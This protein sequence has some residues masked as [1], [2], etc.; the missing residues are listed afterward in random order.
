MGNRQL[1][2]EIVQVHMVN[3]THK[4][5]KFLEFEKTNYFINNEFDIYINV[6]RGW[7]IVRTENH[8]I[9]YSISRYIYI[10]KGTKFSIYCG[11]C[12]V[13][14]IEVDELSW[15][16]NQIVEEEFLN[17][18]YIGAGYIRQGYERSKIDKVFKDYYSNLGYEI[19]TADTDHESFNR[20]AFRNVLA[21][22]FP[23]EIMIILDNDGFYT[24]DQLNNAVKHAAEDDI[25]VKPTNRILQVNYFD[26]FDPNELRKEFDKINLKEID[27][28]TNIKRSYNDY[29]YEY[30]GLYTGIGWVLKTKLW[31][32][33]D[34]RCIGW[35]HE[36]LIFQHSVA[37]TIGNMPSLDN[38]YVITIN[39]PRDVTKDHNT[40]IGNEY[41]GKTDK[42]LLLFMLRQYAQ[43]GCGGQFATLP[44]FLV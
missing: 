25:V 39:H 24:K 17:K 19:I 35:G 5:L 22:V 23:N 20:S 11:K 2:T 7:P 36:D 18:Q 16:K 9:K 44:Y 26:N 33:M 32:G 43:N 30:Y 31:P 3:Q 8:F 41:Y 1:D 27:I 21:T 6:K 40:S 29:I 13:L 12:Y 37:M 38:G 42:D 4:T 14:E 34:E 15:S 10:P 28:S